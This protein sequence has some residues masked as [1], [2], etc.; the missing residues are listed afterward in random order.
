MSLLKHRVLALGQCPVWIHVQTQDDIS[1]QAAEVVAW[2]EPGVE[3]QTRDAYDE[4][5]TTG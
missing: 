1:I 3:N 2:A 5:G 4:Q